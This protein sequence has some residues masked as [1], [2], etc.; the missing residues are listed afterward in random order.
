MAPDDKLTAVKIHAK[1][2]KENNPK[3]SKNTK[4]KTFIDVFGGMAG[5]SSPNA[6]GR[7]HDTRY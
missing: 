1:K 4:I 5:Y 6:H 2:R 3:V 7:G